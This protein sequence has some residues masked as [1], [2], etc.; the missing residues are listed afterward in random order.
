[1]RIGG[2][3]LMSSVMLNTAVGIAIGLLAVT[4]AVWPAARPISLKGHRS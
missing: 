2:H 1:V 3:D 4:V